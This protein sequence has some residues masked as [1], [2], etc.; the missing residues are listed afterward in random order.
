[1]SHLVELWI[2]PTDDR[3]QMVF[4]HTPIEARSGGPGSFTTD[5]PEGS[6]AYAGFFDTAEAALADAERLIGAKFTYSEER[7]D[8]YSVFKITA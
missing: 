7:K 4:D 2:S 6:G 8:D 1:M 5:G 3:R